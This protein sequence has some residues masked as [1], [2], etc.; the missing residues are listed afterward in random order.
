[1]MRRMYSI[2][3]CGVPALLTTG[4]GTTTTAINVSNRDVGTVKGNP[5]GT[6]SDYGHGIRC[7]ETDGLCRLD[8]YTGG[9]ASCDG[10]AVLYARPKR[11]EY[12]TQ[13]GFTSYEIVKGDYSM[14]PLSECALS[15]R[16]DR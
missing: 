9:L 3:C 15:V 7:D 16:F 10:G 5:L 13:N 11:D 12:I 2:L 4:C 14:N 6:Y 8:V 1:M